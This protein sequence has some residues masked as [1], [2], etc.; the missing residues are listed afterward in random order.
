MMAA[1]RFPAS[2]PLQV[3]LTRDSVDEIARRSG[4][5]RKWPVEAGT[6]DKKNRQFLAERVGT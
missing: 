1:A 4:G 5:R 6:L 3:M 2:L